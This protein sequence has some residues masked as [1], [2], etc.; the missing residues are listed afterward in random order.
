MLGAQVS[1]S[2][3][4]RVSNDSENQDFNYLNESRISIKSRS[5]G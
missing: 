2:T 1:K 4:G 5:P 3:R